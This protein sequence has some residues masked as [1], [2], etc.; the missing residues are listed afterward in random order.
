[1]QGLDLNKQEDWVQLIQRIARNELQ[2]GIAPL[3]SEIASVNVQKM[4]Q[5]QE[6]EAKKIS[7]ENYQLPFGDV[8]KDGNNSKTAVGR[9]T[10]Y[11]D[12]NPGDAGLGYVK[13]LHLAMAGEG[14]KLGEQVGVKKE[15]DRHETLKRV[16]MEDDNRSIPA[17]GPQTDWS[18]A[19]I[20]DWSRSHNR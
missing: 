17:K 4:L 13:I 1:M 12:K 15:Q 2:T 11:L 10:A 14:Y 3:K 8:A 16:S 7:E 20:L 9:M 6:Q 18:I 19:D 5:E